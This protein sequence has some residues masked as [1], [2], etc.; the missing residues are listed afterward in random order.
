MLRCLEAPNALKIIAERPSLDERR[1]YKRSRVNAAL[2]QAASLLWKRGVDMAT[3]V[4][5]VESAMRDAGEL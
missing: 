4:S 2:Y 1:K 3:A 5:V